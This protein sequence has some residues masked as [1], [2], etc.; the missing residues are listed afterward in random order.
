MALTHTSKRCFGVFPCP[1]KALWLL[2]TPGMLQGSSRLSSAAGF[3]QKPQILEKHF[4]P[5]LQPQRL[6]IKAWTHKGKVNIAVFACWSRDRGGSNP[7]TVPGHQREAVAE[8]RY[9]SR[10]PGFQLGAFP[11]LTQLWVSCFGRLL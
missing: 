7:A 11:G 8:Q 10:I 1:G 6:Q 9:Q 3:Q 4:F 2:L 5:S